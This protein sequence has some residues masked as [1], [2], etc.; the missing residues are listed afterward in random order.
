MATSGT[1]TYSLT[2]RQLVEYAL[3]KINMVPANQS[4]SAQMAER[5]L[6]EMNVMLKRWQMHPAIWRTTEGAASTVAGTAAVSLSALNPF[7]VIDVRYR[8]PD[9]GHD[10]ETMELTRQE[11]QRL[12]NKT[13]TGTPTQY[14]FDHQR[15]SSTL[16]VWPVTAD[17]QADAIR[18]TYQRRFDDVTDLSQD[19]DIAQE[20]LDTVGHNLAARLADDYGRS[21]EHINRIIQRAAVMF[22]QMQDFDRPEVIRFTPDV[23]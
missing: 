2:A 16:Y 9:S 20:H 3:K 4:P 11:Y 7:R 14:F 12:P 10:I 5:A 8:N 23:R 15:A 18:I 1:T 6:T 22:E 21:G 19:V 17:A 13:T